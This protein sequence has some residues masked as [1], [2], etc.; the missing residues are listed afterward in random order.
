MVIAV[1]V[2]NKHLNARIAYYY[3]KMTVFNFAAS[4]LLPINSQRTFSGLRNQTSGRFD[5]GHG[6]VRICAP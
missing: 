5:F 3:Q 1:L 6:Y 2:K 4:V